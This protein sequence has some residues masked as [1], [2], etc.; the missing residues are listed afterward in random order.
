MGRGH[1]T[2]Q[3][4]LHSSS[5]AP[6]CSQET[7]DHMTWSNP[8]S[9][10]LECLMLSVYDGILTPGPTPKLVGPKSYNQVFKCL[11]TKVYRGLQV[12]CSTITSAQLDE[13]PCAGC[14]QLSLCCPSMREQRK[15]KS[16]TPPPPK[17][18]DI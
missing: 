14:N 1:R 10:T 9:R 4:P 11:I 3:S 15:L 6:P 18:E 17:D 13:P 2:C 8:D 12:C 7:L 16:W 5:N